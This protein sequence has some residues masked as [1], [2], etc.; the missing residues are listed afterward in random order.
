MKEFH[1]KRKNR[2]G[3][4]LKVSVERQGERGRGREELLDEIINTKELRIETL[5]MWKATYLKRKFFKYIESEMRKHPDGLEIEDLVY[6]GANVTGLSSKT[7][8]EYLKE[9]YKKTGPYSLRDGY[10]LWKVRY[11]EQFYKEEIKKFTK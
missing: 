9:K 11:L 1:R 2:D 7:T 8:R 10:L 3:M 6:D 4:A 5:S